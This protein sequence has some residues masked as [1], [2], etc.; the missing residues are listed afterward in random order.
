MNFFRCRTVAWA[1]QRIHFR[2]KPRSLLLLQSVT[3]AHLQKR[4]LSWGGVHRGS[5]RGCSL[6]A[7][8][9]STDPAQ[10]KAADVLEIINL[11]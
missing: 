10:S 5:P 2:F 9:A 8:S 4:G 7:L 1:E 3:D 6:E 11:F